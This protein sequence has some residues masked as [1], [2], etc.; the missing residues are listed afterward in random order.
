M[1]VVPIP[2]CR[3]GQRYNANHIKRAD[4]TLA[5]CLLLGNHADK[6]AGRIS[7][8]VFSR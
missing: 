4:T 7:R 2:V 6:C 8:L 1:M 3:R 5:C